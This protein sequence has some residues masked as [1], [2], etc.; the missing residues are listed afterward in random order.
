MQYSSDAAK[1]A[2]DLKKHGYDF[3]DAYL[4]MESDATVTFEDNRY[5]Y[6]EA[7]F[8]TLGVLRGVLVQIVTAE[9]GE[10]IRVISIR[11]ADRYEQKIYHENSW[12]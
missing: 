5:D 2:S 4:V 6:G 9:M 7:R 11:K 10:D 8:V 1:R 12:R 3:N